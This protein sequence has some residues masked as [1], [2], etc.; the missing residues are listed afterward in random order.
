MQNQPTYKDKKYKDNDMK[1]QQKK[2]RVRLYKKK[3]QNIG[4]GRQ[5]RAGRVNRLKYIASKSNKKL[6]YLNST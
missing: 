5:R 3:M 4:K 1:S 6:L 2:E